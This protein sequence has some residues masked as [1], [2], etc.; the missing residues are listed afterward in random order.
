M[1]WKLRINRSQKWGLSGIFLIGVFVVICHTVR[2]VNLLQTTESLD[3]TC[4]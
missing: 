2:F 3:V 4:R 1:I